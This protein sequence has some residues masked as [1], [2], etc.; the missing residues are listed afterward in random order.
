MFLLPTHL[1]RLC[2]PSLCSIEQHLSNESPAIDSPRA[3]QLAE[4]RQITFIREM[5]AKKIKADT[6]TSARFQA[7]EHSQEELSKSNKTNKHVHFSVDSVF[8]SIFRVHSNHIKKEVFLIPTRR[9]LNLDNESDEGLWY[10]PADYRN[11]EKEAKQHHPED[12]TI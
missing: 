4:S 6:P 12:D 7:L 8:Q 2:H 9:E 3:N 11:F 10:T 5:N 1:P